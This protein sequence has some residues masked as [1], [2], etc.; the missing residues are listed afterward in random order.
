MTKTDTISAMTDNH[1]TLD[2]ARREIRKGDIVIKLDRE[3]MDVL[4]LLHEAGGQ[5]M[6]GEEVRARLAKP[7]LDVRAAVMKIRRALDDT[8]GQPS[9]ISKREDDRFVLAGRLAVVGAPEA[10]P[11]QPRVRPEPA[12]WVY[13]CMVAGM[14]VLLGLAAVL[15]PPL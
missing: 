13:A 11:F 3:A 1:F 14:L 8:P 15:I 2:P 6:S 7:A 10:R 4:L 12:G 5:G 9:V